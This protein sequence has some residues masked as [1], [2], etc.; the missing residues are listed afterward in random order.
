MN[1]DAISPAPG[2]DP[3]TSPG[4]DPGTHPGHTQA[5][6]A[7]AGCPLYVDLDGTLISTDILAEGMCRLIREK[8]I[9]AMQLPLWLIAGR[10]T[11]KQQVAEVVKHDVADLPYRPEVLAYL[12]QQRQTGRRIILATAAT[13]AVALAVAEHLGMFDGVIASEGKVNLKGQAK[14]EAI[15]QQVGSGPFAYLGDSAAD[16][17]IWLEAQEALMVSPPASVRRRVEAAGRAV[18]VLTSRPAQR[19]PMLRALRPT[20]WSKNLLL[21]V[22]MMVGH[23]LTVPN[24]LSVLMG[25]VCFC[26]VAS[27][28]YL[29]NDVIDIEADR[30]HPV[31]HRR[32]IAGGHISLTTAAA[33]AAGLMSL[34][35]LLG[36]LTMPLPFAGL[37]LVYAV[38]TSGYSLV[39]K[40]V[41]LVDVLVLAGLYTLRILAG[42]VAIDIRPS[43]WLLVFS[44][45][46]FLGLA[47]AKRY[48]ELRLMRGED[49]DRAL[50]RGYLVSDLS[51]IRTLG[52]NCS[53]LS[54]MV[55]C[56][57]INQVTTA[58]LYPNTEALW[59]ALPLFL[60]WLF[61]VWMVAERDLMVGDPLTWAL[62]DRRTYVIAALTL[63]LLLVA[64]WA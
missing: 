40:R 49:R 41:M 59:F 2:I 7:I 56:L 20:Q 3:G 63:G 22:P 10:A 61:R 62:T 6:G 24:L 42:A 45:F 55:L 38:V 52:V 35:L 54:V 14:L 36:L 25:F 9:T 5:E 64:K 16:V 21:L 30:R 28:V 39:L 8:P 50:G 51:L 31:K 15:R 29:A 17:P 58:E 23:M 19:M 4:T 32:P 13:Q 44:V 1:T 43:F 53:L 27:G 57:Y 34:G 26:L 37:L 18:H 47:F 60:Y 11:V 33:G 46:L 12:N 48:S